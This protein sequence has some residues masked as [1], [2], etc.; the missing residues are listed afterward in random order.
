MVTSDKIVRVFIGEEKD[1]IILEYRD[2]I[3]LS[4]CKFSIQNNSNRHTKYAV[5]AV[6][7][8]DGSQKTT[9]LHRMIMNPPNELFV[10]H[11]NGNGLDNRRENLRIATKELNASNC[12]KRS[13]TRSIYRGVS[14]VSQSKNWAA[15]VNYNKKLIYLGCFKTE[16][17]A[18]IARDMYIIENNL[19]RVLNFHY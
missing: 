2:L 11:I 16:E 6:M 10:D 14:A 13:G 5:G 8:E 17:A 7:L 9:F 3:H 1:P 4:K 18:A 12:R 15:S 19:N